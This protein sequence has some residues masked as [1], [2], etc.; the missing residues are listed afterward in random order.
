[1]P[2]VAVVASVAGL[3][4]V[5]VVLGIATGCGGRTIRLGGAPDGMQDGGAETNGPTGTDEAIDTAACPTHGQV[6][7]SEVLWI[8]DSWVATPGDQR[9][10]V[11]DL[12]RAEGAIGSSDDYVNR[13]ASGTT[14]AQIVSQ[15]DAQEAGTSK[16]KVL[17]MDGGTW[18]LYRSGGAS[19]TISSVEDTFTQFLSHIATDGTVEHVIYYLVPRLAVVPGISDLQPGMAD[20]CA[21]G[22]VPCHFLDLQ[23]IWADHPDYTDAAN[24]I[25]ASVAG[26]VAIGGA[27]WKIMQDNCIAQ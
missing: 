23:D 12:A 20:I 27:I 11:R 24:G 2:R 21:H 22:S 15:Y 7:A 26:A 1:M 18:D 4:M 6:K 3:P 9:W 17:I 16:V 14:L 8:G 19:G 13:S 10:T 5:L 25:Q